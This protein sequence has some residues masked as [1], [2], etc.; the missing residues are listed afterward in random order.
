MGWPHQRGFVMELSA[1]SGGVN[2][3]FGKQP[4]SRS[5]I[6][7][8]DPS[9]SIK[10]I[11]GDLNGGALLDAIFV[12]Y[13]L[14]PKTRVKFFLDC[15]TPDNDLS[16]FH[17]RKPAIVRH[18]VNQ[19]RHLGVKRAYVKS[20][21]GRGICEGVRGECWLT[22]PAQD[23]MGNQS[24][25]YGALSFGSL[26]EAFYTALPAEP[27][28]EH[29]L[30]TLARGIEA[31]VFHHK[32]PESVCKFLVK[33]HNKFHGGAGVSFVELMNTVPDV[34][35]LNFVYGPFNLNAKPL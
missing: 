6:D 30:R 22:E 35:Q 8:Y 26:C 32:M 19:R 23:A 1:G 34:S 13:Q 16:P 24:G 2:A 10:D 15:N 20:C 4:G 17:G 31:R 27:S 29:L 3:D 28:N 14:G 12:K 33:F 7:I 25:P 18:A 11:F 9:L 5:T 21:Q